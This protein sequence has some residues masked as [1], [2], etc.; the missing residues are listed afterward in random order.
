MVFQAPV[1][2]EWRTVEDNVKLPLEI[3]GRSARRASR[4]GRA[5]CSSS[6]SSA[7]SPALSLPAV[8][9]HAAARGDRPGALVR[10]GDPADG[11]AVRRARRDDPRADELRGPADLGADRDDDRVRDPLDPGGGLPVVAG[12]RHERAAGPDHGRRRRS[13]CRGR[14]ARRRARARATSSSSPRSA[15][16]CG[17]AAASTVDEPGVAS[18]SGRW[19]RAPSDEL[20]RRCRR[21][22]RARRAAPRERPGRGG[23]ATTC[24]P[25]SSSSAASSAG[26]SPCGA[27]PPG[28]RPAA[29]V[30]DRRRA[31]REPQLAAVRT[32]AV[33][34]GDAHRGPRRARDRDGG[35]AAR[36]P[37]DGALGDGSRGCCCPSPSPPTP[38]RS[39]RSRRS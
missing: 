27:R 39:S 5:R 4:R 19:P 2:F 13:T 10:A 1:L 16:P 26:R 9:R 24:R 8:G 17:Q 31:G 35:R 36:R 22:C 34:A 29:P 21:P 33:G 32:A 25:S 38:S 18:A 28:L 7:T 23:S 14:A 12:R 30:G 6:S 37:R 15:R 3:L 11:R 20:D